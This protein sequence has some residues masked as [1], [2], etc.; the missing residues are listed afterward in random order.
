MRIYVGELIHELLRNLL[1]A[2]RYGE[3]VGAQTRPGITTVFLF[4]RPSMYVQQML[5]IAVYS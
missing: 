3:D 5:S 4:V 1:L 2:S